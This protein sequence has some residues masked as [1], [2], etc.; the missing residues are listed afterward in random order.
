MIRA[1]FTYGKV[2]PVILVPGT[3][4]PG[5]ITY[6]SNYIRLFQDAPFADPVWLNIP[7]TDAQVIAVSRSLQKP[8]CPGLSFRR[9]S[10]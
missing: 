5:G 1:N 8:N 4:L 6:G 2:P 9:D 3:L 10:N 7:A